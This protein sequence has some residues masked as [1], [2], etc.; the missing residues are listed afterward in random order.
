MMLTHSLVSKKLPVILHIVI[1]AVQ[2]FLLLEVL[3]YV[4]VG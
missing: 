2:A 4:E 1:Q 3:N